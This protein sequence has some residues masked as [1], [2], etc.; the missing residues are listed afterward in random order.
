M[1]W[2][3]IRF[4]GLGSGFFDKCFEVLWKLQLRLTLEVFKI[5]VSRLAIFKQVVVIFE[6]GFHWYL[7]FC[8][9]ASFAKKPSSAD[10]PIGDARPATLSAVGDAGG[11]SIHRHSRRRFH[12]RLRSF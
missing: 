10:G 3:S 9:A 11:D 5:F 12:L 1:D 8:N 2:E 7:L 6:L 4:R